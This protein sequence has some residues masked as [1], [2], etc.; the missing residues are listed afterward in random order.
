[1][2]Q[3]DGISRRQFVKVG[4]GVAAAGVLAGLVGCSGGSG[5][6]SASAAAS[7]SASA[8]A[9]E[10]A[11]ASASASAAASA[12][13][14]TIVDHMGETVEVPTKI[15]KIADL[16]HAHN[17]IIL[18]LGAADK[19]VGTTDNFKKR[20]WANVVFPGLANVE[21]LVT[22]TGAGEVNYEEAMSLK[23]DVVFASDKEV[24]NTARQNGLT[25]VNVMFQDYDGLRDNVSLTA[26]I[27]GGEAEELATKWQNILDDNIALVE[28][29]MAGVAD[30][31]KVKV[32]HIVSPNSFTK[33]DGLNNIVDEWIKLAGG[34][35]ALTAEGNMIEVTMEDIVAADPDI[36][37]IGSG[38]AE[39]VN[40]LLADEAWSGITAVKNQAVYANP[41]GVFAWD[42]YSGEEA[43][44]VLWAAKKLNP[45]L[46]EDID[47]EQETK[48][49]YKTFY[50]Y[51]LSDDEVK[52]ILNGEEPA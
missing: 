25:T 11:S 1:M 49:F 43:L 48:D 50:G 15:E 27:L 13:T 14:Q 3:Y 6:S 12:A 7:A 40:Q 4:S 32:L 17:Q 34:V 35:N 38:A 5:S 22:G 2:S 51:E 9:S 21:A 42:R 47:M 19:L 16:W 28:K 8:S 23:P 39:A 10:S 24:S 52:K 18:M 31:D 44:Q 46:F 20:G 33:V 41:S 26:Q 29:K 37:I 45:E 30:A 36:I